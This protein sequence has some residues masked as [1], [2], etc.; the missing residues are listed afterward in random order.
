MTTIAATGVL[1][2]SWL[3]LAFPIFGAVVLLVGGRRT[4][5]WGH[6]LGVA[7]PVAAFV[8]GAIAFFTLLGD[9]HRSQDQHLYSWIPVAHF[10]VNMNLLID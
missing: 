3:L 6:L 4:D 1:R 2:A 8:Y 9:S 7:M 5:K 10:Q